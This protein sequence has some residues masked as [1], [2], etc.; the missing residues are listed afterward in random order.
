MIS[1]NPKIQIIF[2]GKPQW[3]A[4]WPY[5]SYDNEY[6]IR[7]IEDHLNRKF[8]DVIFERNELITSYE[9]KLVNKIKEKILKSD[10]VIIFTIGHYGDPGIVQTGIE[11]IESRK[12]VILADV[13]Y[14]GDHTFTK[15]YANIKDKSF[16]VF[17]IS[18]QNIEDF[19][20]P[21][22]VLIKLLKLRGKKILI[23]ASDVNKMNWEVILGLF[24]PERK[25]IRKEHPDFLKQVVEMSGDKDFEFYTDTVG[26][27]QAHQWRKDETLYKN[28][29]KEIFDIEMVRG[30]PREIL[31]Y[32]NKV[33]DEKV[34]K[35]TNKWKR[36]ALRVEPSDKTIFNSAKLYLAFKNL[37]T[38]KKIDI[39][40]PDCGT[41][42]LTG[43][44]PAYPCMAFFEMSNEGL[45]GI[46]ESDLDSTISFLFGLFLTNRPGF[47][48]NQTLDIVKKQITYLHC[49]APN[50][51]YGIEGPPAPYEIVFHGE[52]HF[53]G[54]SP[55]VKFPIGEPV[56]TIKIS[57][58]D[59]KISIRSGKIINNVVNKKGC[60]SKMLIKGDV[61][62]ILKN[63]DWE[64]FGWHRVTFIGDWREEFIIGAKILGLEVIEEDK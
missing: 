54:A 26:L 41:F 61:E 47:V 56:T 6:L 10:G 14:G 45:Y 57:I 27:D 22:E 37:L 59:K 58:F 40:A 12:P 49:M 36:D 50:R 1:E 42:L 32:Y 64:S 33:N 52:I 18:S 60:V 9:D 43:I 62:K 16:Q 53:L 46:C 24:N 5:I 13:I 17:P 11:F 25:R 19:D 2:I 3:E 15:I 28:H 8:N 44:L 55:C 48:S 29:L 20:K 7:S 21:I 23:Y 34:E 31:E 63:F 4:G 39:F 35:V 51:L 38:D 30:D